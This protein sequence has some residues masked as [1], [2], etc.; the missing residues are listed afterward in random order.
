MMEWDLSREILANLRMRAIVRFSFFALLYLGASLCQAALPDPDGAAHVTR[1]QLIGA[2]RLVGIEY[3][4]PDGP[5]VDPFYQADSAGIIIYDPSGW[6]SVH[7]VA[8]NRRSWAVPAS[9]PASGAT[10]QHQRLKA[11]AFDTYYTYSG[12][13]D[14]DEAT[15]V[16]IHHVKAALIPAETGVSY[17]QKVTLEG[18][19]LIFAGTGSKDE[20]IV[21]RKIW[22]RISARDQ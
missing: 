17:A 8:P 1:Q 7:I 6:M 15:S 14:L 16:V 4:G 12:T 5:I 2:W 20:K 11:A 13:W 9:R 3:S 19:R 18:G 22:E 10:A 21:R